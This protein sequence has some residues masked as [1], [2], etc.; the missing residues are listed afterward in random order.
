MPFGLEFISNIDV[1]LF[2]LLLRL[3]PSYYSFINLFIYIYILYFKNLG[4]IDKKVGS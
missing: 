2:F 1:Y 3:L 4:F